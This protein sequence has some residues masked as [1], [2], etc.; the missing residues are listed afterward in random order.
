MG[1]ADELKQANKSRASLAQK[2][3]QQ[4]VTRLRNLLLGNEYNEA[5]TDLIK[6]SD[7]DRVTKVITE[8]ISERSQRDQ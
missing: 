7:K 5:L 6:E 2:Q 1:I 4:K 3:E 8:A